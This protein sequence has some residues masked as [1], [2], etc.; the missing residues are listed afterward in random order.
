MAQTSF[1]S[2]TITSYNTKAIGSITYD[3]ATFKKAGTVLVSY[4]ASNITFT[5]IADYLIFVNE[6]IIPMTDMV[7]S[8]SGSGIGFVAINPGVASSVDAITD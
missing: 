3:E 1:N 8:A 6:V 7:H 2:T 4:G 5:T